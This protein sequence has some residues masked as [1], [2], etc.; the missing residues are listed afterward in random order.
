MDTGSGQTF[1]GARPSFYAEITNVTSMFTDGSGQLYYTKLG[2]PNLYR[3]AFSADSGIVHDDRIATGSQL[4]DITGAFYSGGDLYY[5]TRAD[6]NLARVAFSGGTVSGPPTVVSGPA[7]DGVD[8]RARALFLGPRVAANDPPTAAASVTCSGLT[9]SASAGGSGDSD[10]SIA[11]YSWAWGDGET[12][13]GASASHT[14][15]A[16]GSYQV[17]LTVTDNDGARP[18]RRRRSR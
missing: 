11:S 7:V 18:R 6:G 16:A 8:W 5:A 2:D 15:A 13:T 1:R 4:P 12:S 9:C 10:G 14:Y 3:R 17:T